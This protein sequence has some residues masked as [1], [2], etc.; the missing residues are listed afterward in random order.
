[1]PLPVKPE[2]L[3]LAAA[4]PF[5]GSFLGVVLDRLP[6]GRPVIWSRSVCDGCGARLGLR[7]LLPLVSWLANSAKCRFCGVRLDPCP[8]AM[9]LAALGVVAWAATEIAGWL[10]PVTCALGWILLVLAAIDWRHLLLP[11]A[12]TLPL[13]PAGLAVA[14]AVD[15]SRLPHHLL[16]AAGAFVAFLA[17]RLAYRRFRGREGLGLGD[18]KL[19]TA[20]GAWLSWPALPSVV[21]IAGVAA[22]TVALAG[23]IAGR[24]LAADRAV[25]F[26]SY[27]C[28]AF[29]LVWLHGPL[30]FGG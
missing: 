9:E 1:M 24:S 27:L 13:I 20:A 5:V 7:D 12:L 8:P 23:R 11:D 19:M 3:V 4:A 22:L 6:V 25:P 10:F 26:G 16:G 28:A 17:L 30:S 15:E 29:W 14:Y 2:H 18:V 21:L